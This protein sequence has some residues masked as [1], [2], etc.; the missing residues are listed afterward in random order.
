[1]PQTIEFINGVDNPSIGT[2]CITSPSQQVVYVTAIYRYNG[3][4]RFTCGVKDELNTFFGTM[5][6]YFEGYW[7][8][9]EYIPERYRDEEG[10][11]KQM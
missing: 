1:M 11:E 5:D 6:V 3:M 10:V 2:V 8:A 7:R 9:K 4:G